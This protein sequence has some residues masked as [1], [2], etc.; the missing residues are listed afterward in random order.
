LRG[1]ILIIKEGIALILE[2]LLINVSTR[3]LPRNQ[4]GGNTTLTAVMLKKEE[5]CGFKVKGKRWYRHIIVCKD[6]CREHTKTAQHLR[7]QLII[8]LP[9]GLHMWV[10]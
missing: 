9:L 6:I 5:R 2:S 8:I 3:D 7:W 10:R 4:I 1:A